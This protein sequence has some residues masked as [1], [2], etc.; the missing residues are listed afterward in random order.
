PAA[1]AP[2]HVRLGNV[3]VRQPQVSLERGADGTWSVTRL[4]EVE[5]SR[6]GPRPAAAPPGPGRPIGV[7]IGRARVEDGTVALADA[8]VAPAVATT[9]HGIGLD[10]QDVSTQPA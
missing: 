4:L 7:T 5:P 6:A 8:M 10:V 2:G 1:S 3:V 9:I